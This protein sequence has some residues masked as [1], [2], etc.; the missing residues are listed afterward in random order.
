MRFESYKSTCSYCGVGCGI[1]LKKYPDGRITTEGD[2]DH[3]VN[4]GKLCSKGLHLNHVLADQSD[5]IKTPVMRWSRNHPMQEVSWDQ[6]F[7]RMAAV[8]KATIN[9]FGPDK[10]G[11]YV[12]GQCLTEEYYLINKLAKGF[13][14]TNHIDTNS[15]L[16]MSSAV[17]AYRD[18]LGEDT[19]PGSY[20]DLEFADT[21]LIAGANPAWC[22]PILFR[23]LEAHKELN[24]ETKIVV[25][26]PRKTD[27]CSIAD[28]HLQIKPGTDVILLHAIAREIYETRKYDPTFIEQHT[29][30]FQNYR[31]AFQELSLQKA[32]KICGISLTDLRLAARFIGDAKAFMSWWAMGLNQSTIGVAKN[33]ALLN[34]HL[35]TGQIGRKGSGPFSLTGQPNAMGGREVGGMANL[36]AVHKVLGNQ[37]HRKEVADFWGVDEIKGSPGLTATKMFEALVDGNLKVIWIICTNP[38]VSLPRLDLIE[39]ALKAASFVVVQDISHRSDTVEYAD[40]I[41]PAAGWGEKTGTMTNSE[42]RIGLLPKVRDA[43]GTALPDAEIIWR[44]AQKMGYPGFDYNSTA[45]VYDEYCRMTRG[46]NLDISGLSH[47]RLQKEGSFQWP[48]PAPDHPG[49]ERLFT[50]HRF[51]TED[52]KARFNVGHDHLSIYEVTSKLYPLILTTGRVRDQWHTMTRTGKVKK[53]L[54]HSPAPLLEM[55]PVDAKVRE[56]KNGQIVSINSKDGYVKVPVKI[57]NTIREGVVF[58]PMHWGKLLQHKSARANN[59]TSSQTDPYSKQPGYKFTAVD[60]R[61]CQK[62][63]ENICVVGAGAAAFRFISRYRELNKDDR[64]TVFSKEENPFYNR[65]L[66]PEYVCNKL[67]WEQLQKIRAQEMASLHIDLHPSNPVRKIIRDQKIIIDHFGKVHSYDKLVLCTGSRPYIPRD[68]PKD[69]AGIF[70]MRTK[71]DADC[72]KEYLFRQNGRYSGNHVIVVGG[73]LLGLEI[74]AALRDIDVR[75]TIIHRSD[76]LMERQLDEI[77]SNLLAREVIDRDIQIY[78]NSEV[79]TIFREITYNQ[80]RVTL[81][82]GKTIHCHAVVYAIGTTPNIELARQAGIKCNRGVV[83]NE[84]LQSSDPDIFALGE[85]SEFRE[86]LYGITTAAEQQAITA[87]E[88][89]N[90][91]IYQY[92]QGSTPMNILKFEDLDLCS[93]GLVQIPK[94]DPDYEEIIFIDMKRRY[95]KKCIILNNRMVGAILL[96]DKNEFA[97]FH[98]LIDKKHELGEGRNK[99]LRAPEAKPEIKGKL[100]CSCSNIGQGNIEQEIAGGNLSLESICQK[101]GAGMGCGSCKPEIRNILHSITSPIA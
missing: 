16:C 6:A 35:L 38:L 46:T 80:L 24:P 79:S 41:L 83:V 82:S 33:Y 77:S 25:I 98:H 3:P 15:R 60:V 78:F 74:A 8:F 29:S 18:T 27:T 68:I 89:I 4:R 73:G 70:T 76:K 42:R 23:R 20:A 95:Y 85:I 12:S 10:I 101:T 54:A 19:V 96:G 22:H 45:E 75:I 99:I 39:R 56:L 88:Y 61:S 43:P 71:E 11:I 44:F 69:L 84:Y 72:L 57:T 2:P 55:N 62:V 92:Y 26:D 91:N 47:D 81:N 52:G 86:H 63:V 13:L 97:E 7:E 30:G 59:I 65:V 66:L 9:R 67:Q 49:T 87:A 51:F 21:L 31:K 50:D 48:V 53:L 32:A 90:G 1:L 36:L 14:R 34:L 40:L 5:R 100:I 37:Q 28:L 58:L 94:D 64:I 17:V 93:I